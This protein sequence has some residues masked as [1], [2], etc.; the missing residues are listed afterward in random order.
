MQ[1]EVLDPLGMADSSFSWTPSLKSRTATGYNARGEAWPTFQFSEMSSAGLYTT[2]PQMVH[3]LSAM[4]VGPNGEPIGRGVLSVETVETMISPLVEISGTDRIIYSQAYGWGQFVERLSSG[5]M[6]I[7]HMGGNEGYRSDIAA[8]PEK[9]TAIAVMTNSDLGHELF[10]DVFSTWTDWLGCGPFILA[11]MIQVSRRILLGISGL[12]FTWTAGIAWI[13]LDHWRQGKRRFIF[14]ASQPVAWLRVAW[15]ATL[16]LGIILYWLLVN[17]MME[18]DMP[19]IAC[20]LAW[21]VT[22]I[23]CA[24]AFAL[25]MPRVNQ[26]VEIPEVATAEE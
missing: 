4:M 11:E 13:V 18:A 5:E 25:V 10:A 23:G 15:S 24:I 3:F 26:I 17:P 8:I 21:S 2:A 22:F 14:A 9:R 12:M 19:S 1:R 6:A 7:S 20:V 16:L